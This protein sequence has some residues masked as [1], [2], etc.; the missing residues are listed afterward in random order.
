MLEPDKA[1]KQFTENLKNM[2]DAENIVFSISR[3][4]DGEDYHYH[5]Y[6]VFGDEIEGYF[7]D[8]CIKA[9]PEQYDFSMFTEPKEYSPSDCK[10]CEENKINVKK[11]N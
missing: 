1:K 8:E 11:E 2:K 6:N 9:H 7:C 3:E 5:A 10:D 4:K